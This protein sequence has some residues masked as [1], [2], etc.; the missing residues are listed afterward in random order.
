MNLTV[1]EK[2]IKQSLLEL[3]NSE[4]QKINNDIQ[5]F[6][7]W[8]NKISSF[9]INTNIEPLSMLLENQQSRLREDVP[10]NSLNHNIALKNSL[11]HDDNYFQ[12]IN[13]KVNI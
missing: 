4:L 10:V 1:L 12:I 5:D 6:D 8:L 7:K 11:N 13:I 2:I 3:N 9:D